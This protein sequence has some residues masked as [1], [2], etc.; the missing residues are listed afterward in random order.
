MLRGA[1]NPAGAYPTRVTIPLGRKAIALSLLLTTAYAALPKAQV[2]A[3]TVTYADRTTS[4]VPL[5]YGQNVAAW[6][7][8]ADAPDAPVVWRGTTQA[9]EAVFLR[10]LTWANPSPQKKI[11]SLTLETRDPTAAPTLL[12]LTG[13]AAQEKGMKI[14]K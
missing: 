13:I 1:L 10:A 3:L 8:A 6:N 11:A 14:G 12:A 4:R 2:G 9:G 5:V 7:D